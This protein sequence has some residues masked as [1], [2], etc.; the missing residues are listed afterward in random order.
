MDVLL[1]SNNFCVIVIIP[2]TS[3]LDGE[4]FVKL[5]HKYLYILCNVSSTHEGITYHV[6][7]FH[8]FFPFSNFRKKCMGKDTLIYQHSPPHPEG[9]RLLAS[10]I[11][12]LFLWPPECSVRIIKLGAEVRSD[13]AVLSAQDYTKSMT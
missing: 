8:N 5:L 3:Y 2:K 10:E 13:T 4:I 1:L 6:F 7:C 12:G 9:R 11:Q